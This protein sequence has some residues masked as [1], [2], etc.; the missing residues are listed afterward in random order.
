M[1]PKLVVV[2]AGL[3]V[4][5]LMYSGAGLLVCSGI[6][7]YALKGSREAVEALFLLAFL[8]VT[9]KLSVSLGRW[10]ILLAASSRI[11]WDGIREGEVP[12]I[13]GPLLF[14]FATVA[15][16]S[17]VVSA[18]PLV[19]AL[20][21]LTF[22][23]GTTAVLVG[24]YQTRHAMQHW[25]SWL[26]T[27]GSFILVAS[28]PFYFLPAG[29]AR[30][31]VLF[32]GIT[33]DPQTFGAVVA[34]LTALFTGL[35]LFH[36]TLKNRWVGAPAVL[37]W[38]GIYLTFSRTS[39][40]A[41]VLGLVVTVGVGGV[42]RREEWGRQ[43]G[44]ALGRPVAIGSGILILGLLAMQASSI[45]RY[46]A[47]FVF[48][49]DQASTVV[50]IF[51]EARGSRATRSMENFRR[52]P[53]FGIG[54]G[55]PSDPSRFTRHLE[56]GPLGIPTS[57]TV[58]KGFMPTAV[59]EETGIV[60]AVLILTLLGFLIAP[61]MWYGD[62]VAF[63]MLSTALLV[64]FGE[65]IFFTMGGN[66]LYLWIMMGFCYCWSVARASQRPCSEAQLRRIAQ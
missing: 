3:L 21:V 63:W 37:G 27:M 60:G 52:S 22:A 36:P 50:E 62:I 23:L 41:A 48:K 29:F 20:K 61:V 33:N 31:G 26:Y 65:M 18:F 59:L 58:E 10:P 43:I 14:Y 6:A 39:M 5:G 15:G 57:A 32:R 38:V 7:L 24:L 30:H 40:L 17:I 8:I 54:F 4:L 11:L 56:R 51:E 46:V 66:G 45:Q 25:L 2:L 35:Y 16:T 47:E 19:S 42:L 34:P 64:N 9:S 55:A 44:N 53:I 28:I 12:T 49:D 1:K 13:T